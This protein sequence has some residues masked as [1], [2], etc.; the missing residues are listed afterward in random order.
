MSEYS[1]GKSESAKT[2][3]PLICEEFVRQYPLL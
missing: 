3:T 1:L 2:K